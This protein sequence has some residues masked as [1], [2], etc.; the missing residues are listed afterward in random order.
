MANKH[1][2]TAYL[3]AFVK[4]EW[5]DLSN[6]TIYNI[7]LLTL[8]FLNYILKGFENKNK[9]SLKKKKKKKNLKKINTCKCNH[10]SGA[11][12]GAISSF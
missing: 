7:Y 5:P 11:K 4:I 2:E 8:E 3:F 6:T 12:G 9:A 10:F 1:T